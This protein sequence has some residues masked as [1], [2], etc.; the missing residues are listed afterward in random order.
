MPQFY[1]RNFSTDESRKTIGLYNHINDFFFAKAGIKH[2]AYKKNLYGEDDEVEKEFSKLESVLAGI[3][4][5]ILTKFYPPPQD[6]VA[7]TYL[8]EFILLQMFRTEKAG[9][10]LEAGMTKSAQSILK[11]MGKQDEDI[12]GLSAHHP[13]STLVSL[14]YFAD[15]VPMLNYLSVKTIVNLTSIPF[16]ISDHPVIKY[17]QW[18]ESKGEYMG[19]T[20]L[21]VMGLQIFL[22]IHPRVMICLYDPKIYKC[23]KKDKEIVR[24]ESENDAHQLNGLQYLFS[25]SQLYFNSDISEGY[26][27]ELVKSN[28]GK[29]KSSNPSFFITKSVNLLNGKQNQLILNSFTE[30]HNKLNLSIFKILKKAKSI[31]LPEN[32]PTVRDPSLYNLQK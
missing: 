11:A 3:F 16:I 6:S 22:P 21:A 12:E 13:Q 25:D 31:S 29:K 19:A 17:N 20:G 15:Q 9:S 1:L 10:D 28:V 7:F 23:G 18:M 8:K 5:I 30:P 2:Q 26:I 24:M 4:Q 27:K 14:T 32:L